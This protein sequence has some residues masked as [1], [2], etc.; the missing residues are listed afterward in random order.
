M[1][2]WCGTA[3]EQGALRQCKKSCSSV[4]ERDLGRKK[5][6][7]EVKLILLW[8]ALLISVDTASS[9]GVQTNS[10]AGE[11]LDKKKEQLMLKDICKHF[12]HKFNLI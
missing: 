8:P 12:E 3:Q 2:D 9:K 1:S 10:S 4:L 7:V 6:L 5:K 11:E